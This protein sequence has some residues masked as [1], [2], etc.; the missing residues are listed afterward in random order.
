MRNPIT[1]HCRHVTLDFYARVGIP[2]FNCK[3]FVPVRD[4]GINRM[5]NKKWGNCGFLN[6]LL[7]FLGRRGCRG[8]MVALI[9]SA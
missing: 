3:S 9:A 4:K 6:F 8:T 5:V 2:R 1:M 7:R